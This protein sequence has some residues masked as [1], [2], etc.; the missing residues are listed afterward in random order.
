[1]SEAFHINDQTSYQINSRAEVGVP[2]V[3]AGGASR[4]NAYQYV[5]HSHHLQMEQC[6]LVSTLAFL[7]SFVLSLFPFPAHTCEHLHAHH[8]R[9]CTHWAQTLPRTLSLSTSAASS[10]PSAVLLS[11][12]WFLIPFGL[13]NSY[14]FL[15]TQLRPHRGSSQD[16]HNNIK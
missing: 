4:P 5:G 2:F 16:H 14:R 8:T 12:F 11:L 6:F 1:M 10:V 3:G 7:R 9:S 13:E 15:K